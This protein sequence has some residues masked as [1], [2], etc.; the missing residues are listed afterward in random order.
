MT[1]G[2]RKIKSKTAHGF[3]I[4][5]HAAD[6]YDHGRQLGTENVVNAQWRMRNAQLEE[7][8][9]RWRQAGKLACPVFDYQ[10]RNLFKVPQVSGNQ[11]RLA[12]NND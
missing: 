1:Y 3:D 4:T 8:G 11:D 9:R 6:A 2:L 12:G 10:I 7:V 5:L